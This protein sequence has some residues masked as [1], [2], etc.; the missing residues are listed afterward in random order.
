[1]LFLPLALALAAGAAPAIAQQQTTPSASTEENGGAA[2][3][4]PAPAKAPKICREVES[5]NS[6]MSRT[7]CRTQAEWDDLDARKVRHRE[8]H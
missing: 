6:R 2:K 3:P 5:V 7:A 1:M 8:D 4:A